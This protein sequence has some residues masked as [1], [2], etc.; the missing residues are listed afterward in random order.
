MQK[1]EAEAIKHL[2][3]GHKGYKPQYNHSELTTMREWA[4]K[5]GAIERPPQFIHDMPTWVW[6]DAAFEKFD[7]LTR[8]VDYRTNKRRLLL[9]RRR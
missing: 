9:T 8:V 3:F 7:H 5:C 4:F 6:D 1:E 2:L